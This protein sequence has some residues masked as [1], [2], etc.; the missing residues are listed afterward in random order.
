MNTSV[1]GN[2]FVILNIMVVYGLGLSQPESSSMEPMFRLVAGVSAT[3]DA[4]ILTL[5][6][7]DKSVSSPRYSPCE[8]PWHWRL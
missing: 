7:V 1:S 2:V 8:A 4:S 5:S 3:V 6:L